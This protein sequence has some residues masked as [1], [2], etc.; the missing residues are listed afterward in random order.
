MFRRL[1]A[2]L[3]IAAPLAAAAPPSEAAVLE[4]GIM[5]LKGPGRVPECHDPAVIEEIR[6]KFLTADANVLKRGL[7]I[8][9]VDKIRETYLWVDNPSPIVRRFC[10]AHAYLNDGKHPPLYYLIEQDQGFVG[11]TW[12][13]EFCMIGYE[14]W[15]VHDGTCRTV[16]KWW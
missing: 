11:L 1:A 14:P 13:V 7:L 8:N 2:A 4:L 10:A 15:R 3:A 9:A 6:D 16:R 5:A 12:N